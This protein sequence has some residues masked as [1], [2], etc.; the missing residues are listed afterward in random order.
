[1]F[2]RKVVIQTDPVPTSQ[3]ICCKILGIMDFHKNQALIII[4]DFKVHFVTSC[5]LW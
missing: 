5:I 4:V 3:V 1:M 2:C